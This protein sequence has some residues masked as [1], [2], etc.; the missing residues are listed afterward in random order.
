[1]ST[2]HTLLQETL[3]KWY[4]VRRGLIREVSSI[5]PARLTF[6]ATL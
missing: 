5:P 6:K 2:P 3:T 1:M 4:A